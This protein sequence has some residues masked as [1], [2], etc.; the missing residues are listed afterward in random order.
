[1]RKG[2]GMRDSRLFSRLSAGSAK[3]IRAVYPKLSHHRS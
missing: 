3:H 2:A 1:M